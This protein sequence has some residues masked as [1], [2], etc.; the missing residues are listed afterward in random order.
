VTTMT[1]VDSPTK[2]VRSLDGTYYMVSELSEMLG[3]AQSTLRKRMHDPD[4]PE[5]Q[6]SF[7]AALGKMTIYLYTPD[8]VKR[9]RGL[10]KAVRQPQPFTNAVGRPALY[11]PVE[12]KERQRLFSQRHYWSHRLAEALEDNK[13]EAAKHAKK[14]LDVIERKLDK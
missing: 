6:P 7:T 10:M 5:W 14:K 12:R 2:F 9:I 4:T 13:Q 11:T 8:D 3:I 1:R